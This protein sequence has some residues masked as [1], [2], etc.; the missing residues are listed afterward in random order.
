MNKQ[1]ELTTTSR[2]VK[3]N[4]NN[5]IPAV[6]YGGKGDNVLV[7]IDAKTIDRLFHTTAF[8]THVI[9]LMIDKKKT[10]TLLKDWQLN[11]ISRK[12]IHMDFYRVSAN[13]PVD[14]DVPLRIIGDETCK[15][16][17]DEKGVLQLHMTE[18]SV[19]CLPKDIPE[20]IDVN[21]SELALKQT[22]H[23]SDLQSLKGVSFNI[24]IDETHDP[25]I[26][27]IQPPITEETEEEVT[28]EAE[29]ITK[30]SETN[31]AESDTE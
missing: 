28:T 26:V 22:I 25:A 5:F 16:I 2:S 27:S 6:I 24:Q 11:A 17:T 8:H 18:I 7:E 10:P 12:V 29:N 14:I 20:H 21:I 3:P 4:L 1:I 31:T 13:N 19:T 15:A 9:N 23:A 30:P